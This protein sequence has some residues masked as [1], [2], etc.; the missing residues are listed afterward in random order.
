MIASF[1][2]AHERRL[3]ILYA[4]NPNSPAAYFASTR[5]NTITSSVQRVGSSSRPVQQ[6]SNIDFDSVPSPRNASSAYSRRAPAAKGPSAG[7]SH[8]SRSAVRQDMDDDDSDAGGFGDIPFDAG[9]D[10]GNLPP[11]DPESDSDRTP[12]PKGRQS[13]GFRRSSFMEIGQEDPQDED[14]QMQEEEQEEE[15]EQQVERH[16]SGKQAKGKGKGKSRHVEE[17]EPEV[18]DEIALGLDE[19]EQQ[20]DEEFGD[21]FGDDNPEEEEQVEPSP[22]GKTRKRDADDSTEKQ[23]PKK[24]TRAEDDGAEKPKKPRGRPRKENV[25]REGMLV[26]LTDVRIYSRKFSGA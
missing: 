1:P 17:P 23:R 15:E 5:V 9:Y 14:E 12:V 25:L 4:G 11:S 16:V 10:D 2:P 8:L 6:R 20:P 24:K 19:V 21:D 3:L 13:L 26:V 22:R 18:E 7:P